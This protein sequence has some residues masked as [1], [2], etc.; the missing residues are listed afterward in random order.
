M[1]DLL[2]T[3]PMAWIIFQV[4]HFVKR[5]LSECNGFN[6]PPKMRFIGKRTQFPNKEIIPNPFFGFSKDGGGR[7]R[8]LRSNQ[9]VRSVASL[10]AS[11]A[12]RCHELVS[13]VISWS[14]EIKGADPIA[15][16]CSKPK[17]DSSMDRWRRL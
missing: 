9:G 16:P 15:T 1:V 10:A 6:S 13:S 5:I 2:R 17:V 4:Y 11:I 14:A 8:H 12:P 3:K 7:R